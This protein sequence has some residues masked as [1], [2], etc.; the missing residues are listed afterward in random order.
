MLDR[1][2]K[3][4]VY[5]KASVLK[6]NSKGS[7][8]ASPAQRVV[9]T[10]ASLHMGPL[11]LHPDTGEVVSDTR[12]GCVCGFRVFKL[13]DLWFSFSHHYRVYELGV[14][15]CNPVLRRMRKENFKFKTNLNYITRPC[16]RGEKNF[17]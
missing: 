6:T 4:S 14:M 15:V 7:E 13:Q 9:K 3:R 8:A 2:T 10:S 11:L 16:F 17:F 12:A 5:R 1:D